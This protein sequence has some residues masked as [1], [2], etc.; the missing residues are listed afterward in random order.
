VALHLFQGFAHAL[1]VS[2][3]S[4]AIF[5]LTSQSATAQPVVPIPSIRMPLYFVQVMPDTLPPPYHRLRRRK[6]FKVSIVSCLASDTQR[7]QLSAIDFTVRQSDNAYELNAKAKSSLWS[8]RRFRWWFRPDRIEFQQFASGHGKLGGAYFHGNDVS[9]RW[10]NGTTAGHRWN[11]AIHADRYFS[12]NPNHANQFEFSIAIAQTVGFSDGKKA[13]SDEDFRPERLT[14]IFAPP[15]F[16]VA[17][18]PDR[19]WTDIGISA[20]L[21][22][23]C[24]RRSNTRAPVMPGASFDVDYLGYKAIAGEFESPVLSLIFA[25]DPL[26]ALDGY[27]AWLDK[28]GFSKA[29]ICPS[30]AAGRSKQSNPSLPEARPT[31]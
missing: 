15:P 22:N 31:S 20:N 5:I 16:F 7:E 27:T 11:T 2:V 30:S 12:L 24:F 18:H 23:T 9:A 14:G 28:S 29:A 6:L 25:Y 17:F 21:V 4:A 3:V 10:D 8:D 13:A 1:A 26:D 19:T